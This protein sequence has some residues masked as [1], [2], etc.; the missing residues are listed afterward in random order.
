MS[1][2]SVA[3]VVA[4]GRQAYLTVAVLQEWATKATR[5]SV[6]ISTGC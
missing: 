3:D 4:A 6:S 1:A 2:V 5:A